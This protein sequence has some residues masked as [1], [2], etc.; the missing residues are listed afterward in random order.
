MFYELI[1]HMNAHDKHETENHIIVPTPLEGGET[2][3]SV[4]LNQFCRSIYSSRVETGITRKLVQ[5]RIG[6]KKIFWFS[7]LTG[8]YRGLNF[9]ENRVNSID[10]IHLFSEFLTKNSPIFLKFNKI[11]QENV[12]DFFKHKIYSRLILMNFFSPLRLKFQEVH[13]RNTT[14]TIFVHWKRD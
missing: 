14:N 5:R 13:T 8:R 10:F 3:Y 9:R 12:N 11:F 4:F 6:I 7:F 1:T 2:M